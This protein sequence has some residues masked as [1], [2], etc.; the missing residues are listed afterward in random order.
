MNG[1]RACDNVAIA[2]SSV[3]VSFFS[4]FT[5]NKRLRSCRLVSRCK[6][7]RHRQQPVDQVRRGIAATAVE[8]SSLRALDRPSG[9]RLCPLDD[10]AMLIERMRHLA[11]A[12]DQ[13]QRV[14]IACRLDRNGDEEGNT[15][16]PVR[17]R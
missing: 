15:V 6:W 1:F 10:D 13:P 12:R 7:R 17:C 8:G 14:R 16:S 2:E 9:P 3:T 5:R 11:I 4:L